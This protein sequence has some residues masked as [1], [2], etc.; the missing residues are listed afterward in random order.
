MIYGRHVFNKTNS[1]HNTSGH[2]AAGLINEA[3][4]GLTVGSKCSQITL[5]MRNTKQYHHFSYIPSKIFNVHSC[6]HS[7]NSCRLYQ[8]I[9]ET[10]STT[11]YSV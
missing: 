6:I 11:T 4:K 8:R 5:F 3:Q 10:F 1:I 7:S 9:P 2:F